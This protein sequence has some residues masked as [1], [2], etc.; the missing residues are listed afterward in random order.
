MPV[1]NCQHLE[2]T[3]GPKNILTDVT[4]TIRSGERVGLVGNNGCGKSTLGKILAG[5]VEAE[6]GEIAK[7]RGA[8]VAYLSQEPS[9]P[10]GATARDVILG[11]LEEWGAAKRA[12]D[13][14]TAALESGEG[15]LDSWIHRQSDA[16]ADI[17][18]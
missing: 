7:K 6:S 15:D 17:E 12:Y 14:A 3:F 18:R 16:A 5:E 1:I 9:F 10:A 8:R 13:E 4:L 11:A 2:K